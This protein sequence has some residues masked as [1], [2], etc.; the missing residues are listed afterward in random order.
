MYHI[1]GGSNGLFSTLLA[2]PQKGIDPQY[3]CPLD[4]FIFLNKVHD[5]E[6]VSIT[7]S[8]LGINLGLF[9]IHHLDTHIYVFNECKLDSLC[10]IVKYNDANIIVWSTFPSSLSKLN[11]GHFLE[12]LPVSDFNRTGLV[13]TF[14]KDYI[15][16]NAILPNVKVSLFNTNFKS[17]AIINEQQLTFSRSVKLFDKYRV[18][19]S[20]RINQITNWDNIAI[21]VQGMF[22]NN[23]DNIP[24]LL[25][26]KIANYIE[27]LYNRSQIEMNNAEAV[28]NRVVS[29]FIK[30]NTTYNKYKINK[31]QSSDQLKRMEDEYEKVSSTL[32]S[33]TETLKRAGNKVKNFQE[34]IDDLC[35]IKQCPE[36]CI[37]QQICEE[38][39]RNVT[40]PVQGTCIFQCIKA[41]NVTVIT[42]SEVIRRSEYISQE[43]CIRNPSCQIQIGMCVS[44]TTCETD[45]ISQPVDYVR[46]ITEDRIIQ[47]VSECN[48]PCSETVV[49]APLTALCCA[50]I[51]C[52]STEQDIECLSQNQHCTQTREAV[53]LNLDEA[54]KNATKILQ[55][56]DEAKRNE[57]V[58]NLKLQRSKVNYHSAEKKFNESKRAYTDVLSTLEIATASFEAVKNKVQLAKL[59]RITSLGA[60]GYA[61][62]SFFEIKSVSFDITILTESPTI[63]PIDIV[64]FIA[65]QNVTVTETLYIDFYNLDASLKQGAVAITEK[66]V[67]SQNTLSKR[68][69]RNAVNISAPNENE[70]YF[71]QKCVDAINIIDYIKELNVS[72]FAVAESTISSISSLKDN[73]LEV[74]MLI[75]YSSSIL[76][77]ELT[78]DFQK[79]SK[80]TNR[81]ITQFNSTDAKISEETDELIKLMQEYVLSSQELENELGNT[82]YQSWQAK[83][84]EVH[85][86]TGSAAGFPCIGFSGCLQ[87]VVDTLNDLISD[88][89]LSGILSDFSDAA[90][91]LMDLALLQNYSIVSAVT[92]THKIYNIASNPVITNYW[93][94]STPRIIVHP[95]KYINSTENS[96]IKLSCE[97]EAEQFTSYQWKKD[98]VQLLGQNNSTLVLT[99]V[100]LND[101]GNYS[102]VV[103]NQVGSTSSFNATVEILQIPF[104]LLE[105]ENINEYLGN[106]N[107]AV[108][109]CNASGFPLPGYKWYF[110]PKGTD[111]FSE[112][113]NNNQNILVIIPPLLKDEGSY[114]CE[115]FVG[116]D[117]IH[118]RVANLTILHSTVVQIAQT[119]YLNFSYISKVEET[120]TES[121]GS[122][123]ILTIREETSDYVTNDFSGSGS[124]VGSGININITITPFTKLALE[125]NLLNT[126]STLMSFGS[127]TIKNITLHF[128]N[129]FNLA[130]SFTLYSHSITYSEATLSKINQLAPQAIMEWTDTWKRLQQL[131]SISD[132]I[133]TDYEYEYESLPS[134]L[135]VDMLQIVCPAGKEVSSAN[136]LIC[137]MNIYSMY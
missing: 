69:S 135:K 22:T 46:Y 77:E 14:T 134:S 80:I 100:T 125:K 110:R 68:H 64:M 38:C 131:L 103:T 63:L 30:A 112:I 28:Y 45:Y 31:H 39:R 115:A 59:E 117:S 40:V 65:S 2:I 6:A 15:Q 120:E 58:V 76:N 24:K 25:C 42:G 32:Y 90:Q 119:V 23:P 121:S 122:G 33:I 89:P 128:V 106:L 130:V 104:F 83:M 85:S 67:L 84:E 102:C 118:S 36:V 57:T 127:T 123:D 81:N 75:N 98:G 108:F 97:A 70:F 82:L 13:A 9:P 8:C 109:Q 54:E 16:L 4:S 34:D 126:L 26:Y 19:L 105:P 92:N 73:V 74:S 86:Q 27:I 66:F 72:I 113:P 12:L 50:N 56:L 29:Q 129:P 114:Y 37:P 43:N 137:G 99:N 21:E 61:S 71:Q 10:T 41:E 132:F 7:S 11:L 79:I 52:N 17:E 53:Y 93:C 107:G 3:I 55:L 60:C 35:T 136:N 91:D 47:T 78:L 111:K 124:E 18:K 94:A 44:T 20:G 51:T 1:A 5:L 87:K 133:I 62:P 96:T 101:N 88:I 116:D 48:K 95:V 49:S